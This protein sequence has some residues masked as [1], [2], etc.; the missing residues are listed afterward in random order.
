MYFLSVSLTKWQAHVTVDVCASITEPDRFLWKLSPGPIQ[1]DVKPVSYFI[2]PDRRKYQR[3]DNAT[4]APD[5]VQLYMSSKNIHIF[6]ENNSF[7]WENIKYELRGRGKSTDVTSSTAQGALLPVGY[8]QTSYR[9]KRR[10]YVERP[11]IYIMTRCTGLHFVLEQARYAK[12]V[13]MSTIC[14]LRQTQKE[15]LIFK[16]FLSTSAPE[17]GL[18]SDRTLARTADCIDTLLLALWTTPRYLNS[19]EPSD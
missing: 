15:K 11:D 10:Y 6:T 12:G 1:L 5:T 2:L 7:D 4:L 17:H 13:F 3:H 19:I 14:Y 18:R 16:C 8:L 9:A